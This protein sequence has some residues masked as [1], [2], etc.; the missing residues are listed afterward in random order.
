MKVNFAKKFEK[1][2]KEESKGFGI[3]WPLVDIKSIC[4]QSTLL[5]DLPMTLDKYTVR[6]RVV[7]TEIPDTD[8]IDD[9]FRSHKFIYAMMSKS[10]RSDYEQQDMMTLDLGTIEAIAL[11]TR[12]AF[13]DFQGK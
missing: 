9:W 5:T 8:N 11:K 13:K 2:L 3:K 1:I 6:M 4:Y 7:E 10:V 12:E